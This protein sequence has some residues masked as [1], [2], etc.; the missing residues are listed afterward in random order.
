MLKKAVEK[1]GISH[2]LIFGDFNFPEVDWMNYLI[3]GSDISLPAIFFD[4]T[5]DLF[6]KQ[7]VDF[8]TRFR[9]GNESSMLDL[10]FT[11]EDYMIENLRSIAPLGK[12]DHVGLLFTFITY[13]AI[14]SRVYGGKKHDYWKA[15]M[16]EIN[17][18]LQKVKWEEEMENK[19]VNQS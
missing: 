10:I 9:E 3:K 17:S 1:H 13:S 5:Q 19:G 12:S 16:S 2:L 4:I 6:L 7:H 8:N 18:S 11:N 15:D 14:D